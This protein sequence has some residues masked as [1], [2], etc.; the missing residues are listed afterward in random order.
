V[1]KRLRFI[2]EPGWNVVQCH[3]KPGRSGFDLIGSMRGVSIEEQMNYAA[4]R[5]VRQFKD[6][7]LKVFGSLARI[8]RMIAPVLVGSFNLNS[9]NASRLTG[10]Y[11]LGACPLRQSEMR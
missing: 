5:G 8:L 2:S 11:E 7:T 6:M 4:S 9:F 1:I 3:T 10:C